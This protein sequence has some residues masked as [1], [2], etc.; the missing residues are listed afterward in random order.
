MPPPELQRQVGAGCLSRETCRRTGPF[1]GQPDV[2]NGTIPNITH[3]VYVDPQKYADLPEPDR[4][5]GSRP[6]GCGLESTAAEA[7]VH[8]DGPGRWGSRGDIRLGVSV[9]YS[10]INNTAMLIEI[11]QKQKDYVPE[12]SFGTHFFQDLVEA[13]SGICRC[14]LATG[15]RFSTNHSSIIPGTGCPIYCPILPICQTPCVSST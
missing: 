12:L 2:T 6:C 5:D 3:I 1:L 7:P 11:A 4:S 14:T 13:S 9:T 8:T 15:E 10:D